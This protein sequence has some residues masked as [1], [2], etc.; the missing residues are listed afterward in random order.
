MLTAPPTLRDIEAAAVRIA[1]HTHRTPVLTSTYLDQMLG[2]HLYFKCENFQK[3]G[4][5]KM[6]GAANAV[7]MLGADEAARGVA[8]HSS[9]NHAQ[10]LARAAQSRGIPAYLVMPRNAPEIKK[11]GVRG[12]G[13]QIIECEPTLEARETGLAEVVARTGANF[14]PPYDD[15]RIIAGQAT[16]AYELLADAPPLDYL[17]A[18]VGGGGLLSGT[19]LAAHYL[20]PGTQVWGAEPLEVNDA[21]QSLRQGKLVPLT[22]GHTIAD[23]LRTSLSDKTFGI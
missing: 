17:I 8:T 12:F 3:T 1:P 23:G 10:A 6:R 18:P 2:A 21:W 13:G 11:R 16:C 19:A 22:G 14:V 4:S 20:A 7:F 15:Y 9:G 5:F